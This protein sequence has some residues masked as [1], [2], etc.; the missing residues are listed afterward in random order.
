M[1]RYFRTLLLLASLA[2]AGSAIAAK[3]DA[4]PAG[5]D[6]AAASAA[7]GDK[8]SSKSASAD[9]GASS[10]QLDLNTASEDELKALPQIGDARAKAIVKGRPYARKDELVSKK[11]LTQK[12][13]DGIK[14]KIIAKGGAGKSS[15]SAA[16]AA[17]GDKATQKSSPADKK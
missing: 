4:K 8:A 11:I 5:A 2:F 6:K 14:D 13:Y 7:T 9:K 15:A 17:S 3:D 10:A 1:N 16:S 12:Q